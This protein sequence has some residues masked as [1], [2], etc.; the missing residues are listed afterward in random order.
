MILEKYVCINMD[1]FS[2]MN[3]RTLLFRRKHTVIYYI[4][5]VILTRL[6]FYYLSNKHAHSNRVYT[7]RTGKE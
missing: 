1:I 7:W 6:S 2:T 5:L 3:S 4:Y